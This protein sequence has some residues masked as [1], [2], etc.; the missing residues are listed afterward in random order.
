MLYNDIR[1]TFLNFFEKNGHKRL[2][3]GPLIPNDPTLLFANAGMVQFKD[4]F[5]GLDKREYNSA[6]TSQKCL[7]ISGKH[8]DLEQVGF[9]K[10]HHT[11]F[12][13]LGNFSFGRYF[14]ESVIPFAWDF[15]TK[16][17]GINSEKLFVTVYAEDTE[18]AEIWKKVSGKDAIKISTSDNFWSMG[19][20]GPCGPCS[21]IYYDHG[22]KYS[23][24]LPADIAETGDR[25][26]EIWNLVFMQY[27]QTKTERHKLERPCIDTGMGL[28]RITAVMQ[29]VCDNF[30]IDLFKTLIL[31]TA[32]IVKNKDIASP[33]YRIIADH[34]RASA[35]LIAEG[36]LPSNEG[37]GYVLRRVIRRAVRHIDK[38]CRSSEPLFYKMVDCLISEMG[39]YYTE[40]PE[41]QALI[42]DTLKSEEERFKETLKT[43]LSILKQE[44]NN[45]NLITGEVAFK[46]YDTYG[47][48]VDLT[49]NI[50][51]E[52]GK[53]V[54]FRAFDK[55]L[56]KQKALSKAAWKGSGDV[57]DN[58][59]FYELKNKA[60]P[61]QFL[62]YD[63]FRN[64]DAKVMAIF[65]DGSLVTKC[66]TKESHLAV[67]LDKTTFYADS[68]GQIG[69]TGIIK[70]KNMVLEV[71]DTKKF[72]NQ[73]FIHYCVLKEGIVSEGDSVSTEIDFLRR[74]N[75]MAN[76]TTVHIL[77]TV[78]K[79]MFGEQLCQKGSYVSDDKFH[80]DFNYGSSISDSELSEI[81]QGVNTIIVKGIDV[82]IDVMQKDAAVKSGAI[83][84]FEEKYGDSVRVIKVG[85]FSRELCGGTHVR[86][87]SDI[88]TCKII[89]QSSVS[90]G[91]R[92]IEGV[93]GRAAIRYLNNILESVKRLATTFNVSTE[94]VE[95]SVENLIEKNK[96][97]EKELVVC[98]CQ[99]VSKSFMTKECDNFKLYYALV[100]DIDNKNARQILE[101]IESH[102]GSG[103]YL[104]V[105]N[106]CKKSRS[107]FF[108]SISNNLETL[109]DAREYA[110]NIVKELNGNCGGKRNFAQGGGNMCASIEKLLTF[111]K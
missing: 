46:L 45:D 20:T 81:E 93:S 98:K 61:T 17:L 21:E 57:K 56:E 52:N 44:L 16:E 58:T 28:E 107:T 110:A 105:I 85:D 69:D 12:E 94:S 104:F 103:V 79:N 96:I 36:V 24:D 49:E 76:H 55:L 7:R 68:G 31:N 11:F 6:T 95:K 71:Y 15:L 86:N 1:S 53:H 29:G 89:S 3:S 5:L 62:G 48:P 50:A 80:F 8:N 38:L 92:R 88:L 51:A 65:K 77:H 78:L 84:L 13:M 4:V 27:N 108:V 72:L 42:K 19:E 75:I 23:G 83:A 22:P 60:M 100:E 30:D 35:F 64:D 14:K 67:I 2:P 54:D 99:L 74:S 82:S 111:F 43:G 87:T 34:L 91:V 9:T 73:F 90:S 41:R 26:V 18:A 97:L 40:L 101:K 32:E 47:F 37:R 25:Y 33:S 63:I 10:R 59:V 70:N 102:Y 39:G 66:D 109:V 106:D